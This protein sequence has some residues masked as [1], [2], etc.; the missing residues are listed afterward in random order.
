[1]KTNIVNRM[2][3]VILI[4][5]LFCCVYAINAVPITY[6]MFYDPLSGETTLIN[7]SDSSASLRF[8]TLVGGDAG[9]EF[10]L[11][12]GYSVTIDA[13]GGITG[14]YFT[15]PTDG[16]RVCINKLLRI[17]K[18]TTIVI[19]GR[20]IIV[21][22][23]REV[24]YDGPFPQTLTLNKGDKVKIAVGH[25]KVYECE[26]SSLVPDTGLDLTPDHSPVS[27]GQV[28]YELLMGGVRSIDDTFEFTSLFTPTVVTGC[29]DGGT[30]FSMFAISFLLL[31]AYTKRINF[32]I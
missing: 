13:A 2:K 24:V 15:A 8:R 22:N 30:T 16:N 26:I 28:S 19:T 17:D 32:S 10:W 5:A 1:M 29:P 21:I 9:T 12:P 18:P 3:T 11:D 25:F 6:D 31:S 7:H 4:T 20:T 14:D 27:A 23:G